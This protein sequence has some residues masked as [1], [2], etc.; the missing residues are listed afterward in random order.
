[1]SAALRLV[2]T[3]PSMR[4]LGAAF[5]GVVAAAAIVGLLA[6]GQVTTA[7]PQGVPAAVAAPV[8]HDHGWSSAAAAGI[9]PVPYHRGWITAPSAGSGG[10]RSDASGG[11]NGTRFPQ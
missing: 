9:A 8:A 7:T 11:S 4:P 1:M 6:F 10:S 5:G 2:Q 3:T